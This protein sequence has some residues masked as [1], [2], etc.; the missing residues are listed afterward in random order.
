[1]RSTR[2]ARHVWVRVL[3]SKF[4]S[5]ISIPTLTEALFSP[6]LKSSSRYTV[7]LSLY[8]LIVLPF[9]TEYSPP[10][11]PHGDNEGDDPYSSRSLIDE[12]PG[13]NLLADKS[14][15][16]VALVVRSIFALA[17]FATV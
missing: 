3:R 9:S 6:A 15:L 5:N 16:S 7:P 2:H 14:S 10:F 4:A 17:S 1:M 12:W 13:L 11:P 8:Y